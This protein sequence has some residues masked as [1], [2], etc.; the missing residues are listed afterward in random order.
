MKAL[1]LFNAGNI[2]EAIA[3]AI[4]EVK[5]KPMEPPLRLML[6]EFLSFQQDWERADKQLDSVLTQSPDFAIQGSM[7]RQ[8]IRAE[9]HRRECFEVGRAPELLA[10]VDE[11][12]EQ[13]LR[14]LLELRAGNMSAA[15]EAVGAVE[16]TRKPVRGTCDGEPFEGLRDLDDSCLSVCEVLTTTGK[17][18]WIPF[19]KIESIEFAPPKRPRDLL[20]REA[21]VIVPQGPDGVVFIPVTTPMTKKEDS[22]ELRLGR[23]TE[24]IGEEGEVVYG[25]GQRIWL[26]GENEMPITKINKIEFS[27]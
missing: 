5:A 11:V 21:H 26:V 23:A 10:E 12:I 25:K 7:G 13:Q 27:E 24:W 4:A 14:V 6:A 15:V 22:A 9:C 3:A 20:W 16:Q 8:I 19:N 18:Y 17:Y 2:D 1:E